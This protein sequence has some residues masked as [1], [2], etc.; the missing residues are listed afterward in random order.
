VK[1]GD[2]ANSYLMHKIDGEFGSIMSDCAPTST[3]LPTAITVPCG[4]QMPQNDPPLSA[5]E[6]TLVWEWIA[7]GAN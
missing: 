7:Q 2:P 1:A 4:V 6:A 5:A 3:S